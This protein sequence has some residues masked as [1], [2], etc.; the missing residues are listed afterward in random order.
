[1]KITVTINGTDTNRWH[2][3]G[4]TCNPFPQIPIAGPDYN[5]A[6]SI[7]QKLDS[8]PIQSENELRAILEGCDKRFIELCCQYYKVGEVT[9]FGVSWPDS[10][11]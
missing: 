10:R 4:L 9:S 3:Y 1:M 11:D 6:N 5:S 2:S 8:D 7:L